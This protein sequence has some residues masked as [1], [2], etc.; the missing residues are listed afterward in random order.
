MR[1][2]SIHLHRESYNSLIFQ[3]LANNKR[4]GGKGEGGGEATFLT[5][6]KGQ[7]KH[8]SLNEA[9]ELMKTKCFVQKI[10]FIL[11]RHI[12]KMKLFQNEKS[13]CSIARTVQIVYFG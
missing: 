2:C 1:F 9:F 4:G 12:S 11:F 6:A 5:S 13:D 7:S 3:F 8:F 10:S